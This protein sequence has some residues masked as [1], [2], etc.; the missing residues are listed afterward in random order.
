M[1]SLVK[2]VFFEIKINKDIFL[3]GVEHE[4]DQVITLESILYFLQYHGVQDVTLFDYSCQM[5]ERS[6]IHRTRYG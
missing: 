4:S 3:E 1:D 6:P 5:D 2:D